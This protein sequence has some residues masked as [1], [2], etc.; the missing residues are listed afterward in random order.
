MRYVRNSSS[1]FLRKGGEIIKTLF[2]K[3]RP[4]LIPELLTEA[5]EPCSFNRKE[6]I[7]ALGAYPEKKVEELL[8]KLLDDKDCLISANAAKSLGRI[9]NRDH[10][11]SIYK[12]FS[13]GQRGNIERDLNYL[14]AFHN[15]HPQGEWLETIFDEK[16]LS[17]GETYVQNYITL[18][19]QQLGMNPP[20][21]WIFQRNNDEP[22]EGMIILL[23]EAREME[24]FYKNQE[25][26][27]RS[28]TGGK[29]QLVW[30]V[31]LLGIIRDPCQGRRNTGTELHPQAG[32]RKSRQFQLSGSTV[33]HLPYFKKR[34]EF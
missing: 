28:F 23:D 26:L 4:Q 22:G 21:G 5:S 8:I 24:L 7:F 13:E 19:S 29:Y 11:E 27:Y 34:G 1:P 14:I 2:E 16:T 17:M 15:M 31:V 20:L 25:W 3:K 30:G 18:I 32:Y 12:R 33:F 9:G 10:Y 6:A